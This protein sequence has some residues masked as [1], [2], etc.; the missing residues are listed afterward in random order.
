[1]VE[2]KSS[3]LDETTWRSR[4][5]NSKGAKDDKQLL[6]YG[7]KETSMIWPYISRG[8]RIASYTYHACKNLAVWG[9]Y[10]TVYVFLS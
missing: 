5:W 7:K 4:E 8:H 9:M 2:P 1:M 6:M 10:S 3:L